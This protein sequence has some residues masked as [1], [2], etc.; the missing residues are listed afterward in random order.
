MIVDSALAWLW[1]TP[2]SDG[3]IWLGKG[4]TQKF[5]SV[6]VHS[7]SKKQVSYSPLLE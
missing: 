3:D 1:V 2:E 7:P 6:E 5:L 4:R